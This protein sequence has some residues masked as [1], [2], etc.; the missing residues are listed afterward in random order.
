MADT[1]ADSLRRAARR[2]F[3][4]ARNLDRNIDKAVALERAEAVQAFINI[5]QRAMR[6]GKDLDFLL[7]AMERAREICVREASDYQLD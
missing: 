7:K 6:E 5:I 2:V 1:S 3:W 4:E